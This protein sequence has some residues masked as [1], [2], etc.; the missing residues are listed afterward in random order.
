MTVDDNWII[1]I[2]VLAIVFGVADRLNEIIE[3]IAKRIGGGK[4]VTRFNISSGGK[5]VAGDLV[6]H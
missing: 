5:I 1:A 6:G 3:A 2:I 4:E